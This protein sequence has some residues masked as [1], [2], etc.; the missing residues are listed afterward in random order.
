MSIEQSERDGLRTVTKQIACDDPSHDPEQSGTSSARHSLGVQANGTGKRGTLTLVR[1]A[2]QRQ[3]IRW[4]DAVRYS[5]VA[6]RLLLIGTQARIGM[7][8]PGPKQADLVTRAYRSAEQFQVREKIRRRAQPY[9]EGSGGE[10]WREKRIAWSRYP[11][12]IESTR[13]NRTIILKAPR[14][15]GEK[16]VLLTMFEYNWLRL[17]AHSKALDYLNAHFDI[18]LST[19]WSPTDYALLALALNSLKGTVFVQACNYGEISWIE[20]FHPRLKCLP[21]IACDWINPDC[22]QPRPFAERQ[23]D[24][25]MVA[26]WAPFKRHWQFFDALRKMPRS[27]RITLIGQ[28]EGKHNLAMLREQAALFGVKQDIHFVESIPIDEV[29][30]YQCDSKTSLILTRREGCCVAAVESLFANSPLGM[31]H[32]AHVGPKAYI[33]EQTGVLLTTHQMDKQLM[34]FLDRSEGFRPRAWAIENISCHRSTAKLNELLKA[35][36]DAEG[37]PW[38]ADIKTPYWRPYPIYLR[39]SDREEL[40]PVYEELHDRFPNMI[41]T[42]LPDKG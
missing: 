42:D 39:P 3:L 20:Q 32:N 37:R 13:L 36:A 34:E 8:S 23:I 41:G 16:G 24:I 25:L 11:R 7:T 22:Y 29:A 14:P 35:Q 2:V 9:L 40:R 12:A 5:P 15:N 30:R 1:Q 26:N 27:L 38:T 33:N 4:K 10:I 17:L 18:I 19:S 31:M 21:S 28:D 6:G